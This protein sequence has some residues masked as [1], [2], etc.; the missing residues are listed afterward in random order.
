MRRQGGRLGDSMTGLPGTYPTHP[1]AARTG[2]RARRG[3]THTDS[4]MTLLTHHGQAVVEPKE[5]IADTLGSGFG[6]HLPLRHLL[7]PQG[8]KKEISPGFG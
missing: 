8:R 1:E 6:S 3:R 7:H 5:L 4:A 2:R